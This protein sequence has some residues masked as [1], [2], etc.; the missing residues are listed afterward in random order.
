MEM[1]NLESK[2]GTKKV[3]FVFKPR[4]NLKKFCPLFYPE[5]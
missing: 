1:E 2:V 3:N 5:G 4:D